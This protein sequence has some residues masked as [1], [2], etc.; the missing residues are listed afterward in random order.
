[1]GIAPDRSGNVWVSNENTDTL[2]MFFGLATP[3]VTPVQP[4][5]TVP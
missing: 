3:T 4:V 1:L 5:P 2:V